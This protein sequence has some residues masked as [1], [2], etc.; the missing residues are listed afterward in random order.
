MKSKWGIA[1]LWSIASSLL[2]FFFIY[3]IFRIVFYS[4][5]SRRINL[6]E[7]LI[8][9]NDEVGYPDA[10]FIAAALLFLLFFIFFYKREQRR[11]HQAH[12]QQINQHVQKIM[13]SDFN[14]KIPETADSDE[15]AQL[16]D[17]INRLVQKLRTALEEERKAEQAKNELI[18]NVSHDLRTPLTSIT[19]YLGLVDQDKYRDEVELRHYIGMAYEES[20]R[21][22]QLVHDL[23]EYTRLRNNEMKLHRVQIDIVEMF[24]QITE[25]FQLR[26]LENK[27]EIRMEFEQPRLYVRA[28][29]NKLRRVFDNLMTNAIKYGHDGTYLDIHGRLD[30]DEVVLQIINY[31][32]EIPEADLPRIFDRFFRVEKS[33][34]THYGGSG[35]GLAIAKQIM[36]LHGGSIEAYSDPE[37]T[38]F[39]VRLKALESGAVK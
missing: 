12:L 24:R 36:D 6:P 3:Q 32:E 25:Q 39:T 38:V 14:H 4:G 8:W 28:D 9:I 10:Y 17:N 19:G 26:L 5:Y 21:L 22:N 13:D 11:R 7:L 30:G 16:T 20:L 34:A 1:L 33:R 35:I 2:A 23:F 37:Q 29:G 15:L 18:T 27:M 31:G